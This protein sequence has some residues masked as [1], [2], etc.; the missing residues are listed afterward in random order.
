M[1]KMVMAHGEDMSDVD[2]WRQST[3]I[4]IFKFKN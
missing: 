2:D 1:E 3:S 4:F